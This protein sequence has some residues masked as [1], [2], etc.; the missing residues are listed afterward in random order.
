MPTVLDSSE[1]SI[2]S[3]LLLTTFDFATLISEKRLKL[4][5]FTIT[6]RAS[7]SFRHRTQN[8]IRSEM[9]TS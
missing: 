5:H 4:L 8:Q 9:C 2:P 7:T 1:S 3:F 6:A